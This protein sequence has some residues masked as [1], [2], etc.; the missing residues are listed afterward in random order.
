MPDFSSF[1][2]LAAQLQRVAR[3]VPQATEKALQQIGKTVERAAKDKI[4]Y[5]QDAS[6]EFAGWVQLKDATQAARVRQGFTANDPLLTVGGIYGSISSYVYS[7]GSKMHILTLGSDLDLGFWHEMGTRTIP[8]RPFIGPS[9][10]E[11]EQHAHE[12]LAQAIEK[13]FQR[14]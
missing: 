4:G 9:M 7:G 3:G 14:A 1:S 8:P 13:L 12:V 5:Y 11:H 10:F 6:G 2:D